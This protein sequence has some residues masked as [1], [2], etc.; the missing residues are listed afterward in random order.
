MFL[1]SAGRRR[2]G[3]TPERWKVWKDIGSGFF[4]SRLEDFVS[5]KSDS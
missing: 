4:G 5:N 3:K 2:K 1:I